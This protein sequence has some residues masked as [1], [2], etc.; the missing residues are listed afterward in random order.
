MSSENAWQAVAAAG[1][2]R[3]S[4]LLRQVTDSFT[5]FA[6][7]DADA[8]PA[9]YVSGRGQRSRPCH[10]S[11]KRGN[12][13]LAFRSRH[14][15]TLNDQELVACLARLISFSPSHNQVPSGFFDSLT[16][17]T[18]LPASNSWASCSPDFFQTSI[19][20]VKA[21]VD[22]LAEVQQP[23]RPLANHLTHLVFRYSIASIAQALHWS[24]SSRSARYRRTLMLSSCK[25]S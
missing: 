24:L 25:G 19:T 17:A 6:I 12:W 23:R 9:G 13:P 20:T 18:V 1:R 10:S 5:L 16:S 15:V 22:E 3:E 8:A 4:E 14:F 7:A 11:Q 21:C 2:T